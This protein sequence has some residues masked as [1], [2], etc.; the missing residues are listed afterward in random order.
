[1]SVHGQMPLP[2]LDPLLMMNRVKLNDGHTGH[3]YLYL[4]NWQDSACVAPLQDA[5]MFIL[6]RCLQGTNVFIFVASSAGFNLF[7]GGLS[8]HLNHLIA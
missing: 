3:S 5:D 4:S 2:R 6:L 1:M 7:L 8:L